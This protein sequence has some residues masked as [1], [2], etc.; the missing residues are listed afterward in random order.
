MAGCVSQCPS[1]VSSRQD[2][3]SRKRERTAAVEVQVHDAFVVFGAR[4]FFQY[5]SKWGDVQA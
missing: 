3:Q 2:S 5:L 1:A 4:V